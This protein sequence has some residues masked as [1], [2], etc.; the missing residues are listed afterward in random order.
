MQAKARI[1][2]DLVCPECEGAL[3]IRVDREGKRY[4]IC[5]TARCKYYEREFQ[6]PTGELITKLLNEHLEKNT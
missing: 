2:F 5:K 6:I 1:A 4:A 3:L